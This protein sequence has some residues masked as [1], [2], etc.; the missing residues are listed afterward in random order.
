[1]VYT[2]DTQCDTR[3]CR[4]ALILLCLNCTTFIL[5][6]FHLSDLNNW[7]CLIVS[8]LL[9]S[10]LSTTHSFAYSIGK[11]FSISYLNASFALDNDRLFW[12]REDVAFSQFH[13][14]NQN[15]L[16]YKAAN[17]RHCR[18]LCDNKGLT[19]LVAIKKFPFLIVEVDQWWL[20][21]SS[22]ICFLSARLNGSNS[23]YQQ[24]TMYP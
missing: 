4:L 3:L 14:Y 6:L 16:R 24:E 12:L 15:I 20:A 7:E 8:N 13:F 5:F 2:C 1:M 17:Q 23:T 10:N 19:N 11:L 21:Y 9:F 22:H 18:D